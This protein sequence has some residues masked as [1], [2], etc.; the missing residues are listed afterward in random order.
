VECF[1]DI[2]GDIV[3]LYIDWLVSLMTNLIASLMRFEKQ[4]SWQ[5]FEGLYKLGKPKWEDPP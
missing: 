2:V 5:V 1:Q 3:A 4:I